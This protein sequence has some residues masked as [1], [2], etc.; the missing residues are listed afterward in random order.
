MASLSLRELNEI[1][2]KGGNINAPPIDSRPIYKLQTQ[3]TNKLLNDIVYINTSN[4]SSATVVQLA[5]NSKIPQ[6]SIIILTNKKTKQKYIF[7]IS[8]Y[9]S[10]IGGFTYTVS[11][12]AGSTSET[13]EEEFYIEFGLS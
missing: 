1:A 12:I 4:I 3:T 8:G 11:L 5:G 9:F 6:N 10:V 13:F 7:K 2:S